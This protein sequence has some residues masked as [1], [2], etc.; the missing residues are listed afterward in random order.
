[1][2]TKEFKKTFNRLALD[3]GFES[4]F[5]AWFKESD[6]VILA[7]ILRKSS[8]S[9]LYYLR[10]KLNLKSA[11]GKTFQREKEWIKHDVAHIMQGPS[12]EFTDIFDRSPPLPGCL[13]DACHL[14]VPFAL[15]LLP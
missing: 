1:M 5:G 9:K 11:F 10:I 12:A 3:N 15:S 13:P 2:D 7:L 8:Y 6:E 4:D 14:P